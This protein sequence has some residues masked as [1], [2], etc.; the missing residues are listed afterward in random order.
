M[1]IKLL[2]PNNNLETTHHLDF[3]FVPSADWVWSAQQENLDM[4]RRG[5]KR[6]ENPE[7]NPEDLLE[8]KH[9]LFDKVPLCF[10]F[11]PFDLTFF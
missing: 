11:I 5:T 10:C 1:F 4:S 2:P 7:E 8:L 3:E 9:Q 6:A